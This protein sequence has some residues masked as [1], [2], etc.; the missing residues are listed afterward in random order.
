MLYPPLAPPHFPYTTLFRS[1]LRLQK[2]ND[3]SALPSRFV[4]MGFSLVGT[5][6]AAP[7]LSTVYVDRAQSVARVD[8]KST[9]LNSQSPCKLVCRLLLEKKKLSKQNK[10]KTK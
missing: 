8:R 10:R 5:A 4:S 1:V 3:K 9:R 6:D 7:F 2:T